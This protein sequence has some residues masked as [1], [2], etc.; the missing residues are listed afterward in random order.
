MILTPDHVQRHVYAESI[1]PNLTAGKALAFGHGFNI[2]FGYIKPPADVDVFMVAPKGPGHLVRREFVGRQGRAVPDRGRA[3]R[4]RRRRGVGAVLRVGD[5][6]RPGRRHQDHVHRG[7]RDRPLRRAGGALR[8]HVP[9]RAARLRDAGQRRLPARDRLLRVPA[10]A[11]ADRRPH[12]RGRHRQAALVGVGHRGV[13]R[14]RLRP[15]GHR[16]PRRG[17][18]AGACWPTSRTASFAARFIADQDAGAPEFKQAPRRAGAA[19]D[20][21]DRPQAASA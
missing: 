11:E 16:R 20:R 18:H 1:E 12:V 7:D 21:G 9:A 13:R 6:R 15:A 5:R 2:R 14:L 10:R 19:P 3:G 8:R 4:H 17:E